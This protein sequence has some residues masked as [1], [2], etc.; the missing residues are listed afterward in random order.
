MTRIKNVLSCPFL[1]RGNSDFAF[2]KVSDRTLPLSDSGEE[3]FGSLLVSEPLWLKSVQ[4]KFR[5]TCPFSAK[6]KDD[7]S[8]P[9]WENRDS[10]LPRF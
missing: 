1:F 3:N 10:E 8:D 2:E 4:S 5:L 9:E 6:K 7:S